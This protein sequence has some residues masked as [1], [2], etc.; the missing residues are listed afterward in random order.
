MVEADTP[1]DHRSAVRSVQKGKAGAAGTE[2]V[3]PNA[4]WSWELVSI[5]FNWV[6]KALLCAFCKEAHSK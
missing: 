6:F 4:A 5:F 2:R 1:E 3:V